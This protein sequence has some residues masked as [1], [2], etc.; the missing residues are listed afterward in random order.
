V[1]PNARRRHGTA[2]GTGFPATL[3]K[4]VG[5]IVQSSP[6]A[7]RLTLV[8]LIVGALLVSGGHVTQAILALTPRLGWQ[9]YHWMLEHGRFR[10]LG[11]V[12]S[13]LAPKSVK[14]TMAGISCM[15]RSH[16]I[17]WA[18]ARPDRTRHY[19]KLPLQPQPTTKPYR[20][21][22]LPGFEDRAR[23]QQVR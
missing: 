15:W 19:L 11:L 17:W 4:W 5:E 16:Y 12:P 9:A 7:A 14:T 3:C 22:P 8:K 10:L 21:D 18:G 2:H 23:T 20:R 13:D 1:K 6:E